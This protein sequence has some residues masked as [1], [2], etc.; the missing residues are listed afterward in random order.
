MG[1]PHQARLVADLARAVPR[2]GAIGRATVP[3]MPTSAMSSPS[4]LA[5]AGSRMKVESPAKRG[6]LDASIGWKKL[7]LIVSAP[8][9]NSRLT[10]SAIRVSQPMA[11]FARHASTLGDL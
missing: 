2:A 11:L 9:K 6:T 8:Q 10:I 3:G 5:T 7:L 1:A 4:A